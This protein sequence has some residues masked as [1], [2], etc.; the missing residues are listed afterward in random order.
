MQA[1]QKRDGIM[2]DSDLV[3]LDP[4]KLYDEEAL[5]PCLPEQYR[6]KPI[7][8]QLLPF[9]APPNGKRFLVSGRAVLDFLQPPC[10]HHTEN[11]R[12]TE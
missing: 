10:D 9:G 4:Y 8:R 1:F 3:P 6:K 12:T 11:E 2:S 7:V 5:F